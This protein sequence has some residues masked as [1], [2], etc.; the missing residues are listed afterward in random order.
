LKDIEDV[1]DRIILLDKGQIIY[2]GEKL[3]NSKIYN[4]NSVTAEIILKNK[5]QNVTEQLYDENF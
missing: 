5:Q 4:G 1:C 3:K 2:D